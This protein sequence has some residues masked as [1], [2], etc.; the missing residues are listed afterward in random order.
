MGSILG[1]DPSSIQDSWKTGSFHVI[2]LT[3]Q[4][5]NQP[6]N[7]GTRLKT[8]TTSLVEGT[9]IIEQ[10]NCIECILFQ[11]YNIRTSRCQHVFYVLPFQKS[12]SVCCLPPGI[13]WLMHASL[14]PRAHMSGY[15]CKQIMSGNTVKHG[16]N[17]IK[18]QA[19]GQSWAKICL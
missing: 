19:K 10:N 5:T 1:R 12:L 14:L 4:P 11:H 7:A 17:S 16:C 15:G 3:N 2:L 9:L 13:M 8:D 18:S 6:T